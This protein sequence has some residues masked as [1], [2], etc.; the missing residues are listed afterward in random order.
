MQ[1]GGG[2][3]SISGIS[4]KLEDSGFSL[5]VAKTEGGAISILMSSP[6]AIM[7]LGRVQSNLN[8]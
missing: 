1:N 2:I 3:F 8:V 4:L 5:N 7:E 6:N